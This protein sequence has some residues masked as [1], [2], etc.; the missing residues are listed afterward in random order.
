MTPLEPNE[1]RVVDYSV[2]LG[3]PVAPGTGRLAVRLMFRHLPPYF[4][5]ALGQAQPP[6]EANVGPM[7]ERLLTTE[8]VRVGASF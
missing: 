7:V 3:T 6:G 1:V 5:R 2:A 4:V 8:M